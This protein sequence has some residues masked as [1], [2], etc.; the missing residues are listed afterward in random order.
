MA[1]KIYFLVNQV[2]VFSLLFCELFQG[3]WVIPKSHWCRNLYFLCKFDYLGWKKCHVFNSYVSVCPMESC[4]MTPFWKYLA[5]TSIWYCT[6]GF[7]QHSSGSGL[8]PGGY[9]NIKTLTY[10]YKNSHYVDK[11]I[12]WLSYLYNGNPYTRTDGL[13]AEA[14]PWQHQSIIWTNVDHILRCHMASLGHTDL[15]HS[16]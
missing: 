15:I 13:Y 16:F 3:V 14:G 6:L 9:F 1:H 12:S 2:M 8:A 5:Q 11:T 10:W 7:G 4:S